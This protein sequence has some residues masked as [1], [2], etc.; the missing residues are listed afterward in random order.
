MSDIMFRRIRGRIVPI[1]KKKT[2]QSN[3]VLTGAKLGVAGVL[4]AVGGAEMSGRLGQFGKRQFFAAKLF[5]QR[6]AN[7]FAR[8]GIGFAHLGKAGKH[9]KTGKRAVKAAKM[10]HSG[11]ALVGGGLIAGGLVHALFTKDKRD[12]PLRTAAIGTAVVGGAT[13]ALAITNAIVKKRAFPFLK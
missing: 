12:N 5:T 2:E 6:G 3:D 9:L 7:T 8:G 4:A 13:G 1:K 10:L 11:S